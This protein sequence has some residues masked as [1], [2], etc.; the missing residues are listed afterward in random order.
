MY[1]K[2]QSVT[3]GNVCH[4]LGEKEKENLKTTE[5]EKKAFSHIKISEPKTPYISYD[6]ETDKILGSSARFS[7]LP[8]KVDT[9]ME[10]ENKYTH[11]SDWTTTA[12]ESELDAHE[13][14]DRK[15]S[16]IVD[17]AKYQLDKQTLQSM[18]SRGSDFRY[19]LEEGEVDITDLDHNLIK[20][21][22]RR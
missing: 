5:E 12:S 21:S 13:I 22:N 18:L 8:E 2:P 20:F 7:L 10:E 11:A 4:K 16:V 6:V 19:L 3:I 14:E 1:T 9:E 17:G 15:I